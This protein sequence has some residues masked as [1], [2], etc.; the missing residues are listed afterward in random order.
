MIQFLCWDK[1]GWWAEGP[2]HARRGSASFQ[3]QPTPTP[4]SAGGTC[5][6]NLGGWGSHSPAPLLGFGLQRGTS[7]P[8]NELSVHFCRSRLPVSLQ[9]LQTAP[10][11][12]WPIGNCHWTR[13]PH[14]TAHH[15]PYA[16]IP[17]PATLD[18]PPFSNQARPGFWPLPLSE[19]S[20]PQFSS[21]E[22]P[23]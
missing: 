15:C 5:S 13:W 4:T 14:L 19:V 6:V 16:P 2:S 18:S 7:S 10:G 22:S 20:F 9:G 21:G 17:Q 23:I 12:L 8:R 11:S 3:T 1:E